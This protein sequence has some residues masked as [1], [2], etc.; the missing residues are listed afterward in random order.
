MHNS[1]TPMEPITNIT[2][3]NKQHKLWPP[4][5]SIQAPELAL[6]IIFHTLQAY[7]YHHHLTYY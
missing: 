7:D 2:K 6:A 4:V 3:L 1:T 5:S